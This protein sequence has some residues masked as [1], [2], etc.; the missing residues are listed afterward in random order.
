MKKLISV[1]QTAE[2]TGLSQSTVRRKAYRREW[3]SYKISGR[4]LF[5]SEY[6][7]SLIASSERPQQAK[8]A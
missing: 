8:A 2:Q 4:L 1:E 6:I 3:S 5:D 7:S